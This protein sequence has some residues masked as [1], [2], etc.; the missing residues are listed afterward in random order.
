[1]TY[2]KQKGGRKWKPL[3]LGHIKE[4]ANAI[5]RRKLS[6]LCFSGISWYLR[7]S[8]LWYHTSRISFNDFENITTFKWAWLIKSALFWKR[9][10]E[11]SKMKIVS[12]MWYR[13]RIFKD[14]RDMHCIIKDQ[15]PIL[16]WTREIFGL[17]QLTTFITMRMLTI[18]KNMTYYK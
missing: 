4:N 6:F 7:T 1:M 9:Y 15:M 12:S 5:H 11:S 16:I 3:V 17:M 13:L 2:L 8:Q 18:D 10:F 14:H